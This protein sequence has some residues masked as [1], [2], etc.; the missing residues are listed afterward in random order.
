M[1]HCIGAG[2]YA[3]ALTNFIPFYD[4]ILDVSSLV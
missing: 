4:G 3:D 2:V 1:G